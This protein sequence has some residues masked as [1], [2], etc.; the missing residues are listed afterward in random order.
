MSNSKKI[1]SLLL[2]LIMA[3][4][5]FA[6]VPFSA[7]AAAT[8]GQSGDFTYTLENGEATI[9]GYTG[10]NPTATVP[11]VIDGCPVTKIGEKAFYESAS[12]KSVILP[13]PVREI[14]DLAFSRCTQLESILI[15]KTLTTVTPYAFDNTPTLK[16]VTFEEGITK[17]PDDLFHCSPYAKTV[18]L[19]QVTIP[20]SVTEI[21]KLAFSG[22]QNLMNVTFAG[23]AVTKIDTSA[24]AY[25]GFTSID[26]PDNLQVLGALAFGW[27]RLESLEIPKSLREIDL[28]NRGCGP[29]AYGIAPTVFT[30]EEGTTKIIPYL[31]NNC[32][33][34]KSIQLPG[35]ITEIGD[36][37]FDH[38]ENL[39]SITIPKS[40]TTV[41]MYAFGYCKALKNVTF[42]EGIT[43]IPDYLLFTVHDEQHTGLEQVTIPASV[44]EIGRYAFYGCNQ[45]TD[46]TFAGDAVTKIGD[47]AFIAPLKTL[48]LPD[49]I[50]TLGV[51]AFGGTDITSIEIPKSLTTA[52]ATY[53][54]DGPFSSCHLSTVTFEEGT[55]KVIANLFRGCRGL[56]N[57]TI[58]DTFTEIGDNAFRACENLESITIPAS[59][60]SIGADAFAEIENLTICGYVG[61]YAEQYAAE[62]G[63]DFLNIGP[64]ILG[65]VDCDGEVNIIDAT[66]LQRYLVNIRA[67]HFNEAAADVDADGTITIVDVT[68]LSRSL[69]GIPTPCKGIGEPIA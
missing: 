60:T 40:L 50:Q 58:P 53:H 14:G 30:F 34:L 1:I 51:G 52:D 21:G 59:V 55:T 27:N 44:T 31:F 64:A 38:C 56:T 68:F 69:V 37:A 43:K 11:A 63:I 10:S 26:L 13:D 39:E 47:Y 57:V 12:V 4:S 41:A 33:G 61:S 24:F 8:G 36:L 23:D 20:A 18:N 32:T 66:V 42:E 6:V 9:T 17:I 46:V 45:L 49:H 67:K 35:T 2:S 3:L 19:E 22:C 62:K 7:A 28:S 54:N 65:D 29:F 15:P 48:D 25:C 16:T 5:V